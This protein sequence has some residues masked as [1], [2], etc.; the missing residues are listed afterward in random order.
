LVGLATW[1]LV[2][3]FG[4]RGLFA[5][6]LKAG[7][8]APILTAWPPASRLSFRAQRL[9]LVMFAH[10]ECPCT[11]ASLGELERLLARSGGR[12][13]A[14]VCFID[15]DDRPSGWTDPGLEQEARA[16]PGVRVLRDRNGAL[17]REFG[18]RTSGQVIMFD[19]TGRAVFSGGITGSRGHAG[20]NGGE[21]AVISLA[22]G[23]AFLP[24]T[25]PVY[26][27]ALDDPATPGIFPR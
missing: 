3:A 19:R 26:G 1:V 24:A 16:I 10:P 4:F 7:E 21:D 18:A 17:A 5:Y 27:C 13:A 14:T 9:N 11:R 12:I 22:T 23:A 6:E 8:A 15:P 25:A 20:E 2:V